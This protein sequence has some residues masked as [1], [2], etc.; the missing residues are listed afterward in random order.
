[1]SP[2]IRL[3]ELDAGACDVEHVIE[4]GA[5]DRRDTHASSL[6]EYSRLEASFAPLSS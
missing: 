1:M 5:K 3:L 2:T 4:G 6:I